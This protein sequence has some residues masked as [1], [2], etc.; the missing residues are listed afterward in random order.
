MAVRVD[1]LLKM[2]EALPDPEKRALVDGL[3]HQLHGVDP[4]WERAWID[5]VRERRAAYQAGELT[6]RSY[7]DVIR[8][9]RRK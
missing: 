5:E 8:E 9:F 7:K 4:D 3:L 2:A 1:D 6:A